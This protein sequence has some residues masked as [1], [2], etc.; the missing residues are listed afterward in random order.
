MENATLPTLYEYYTS[1]G[2]QSGLN[3]DQNYFTLNERNITLYSGAMHYFRTPKQL[4]RDRLRKMRAA[5]LN[6]VETYVA[7][8]LHE[9]TPGNFDFGE[10]GTDM[11]D[12]LD[13]E[14]FLKTAQEEDLL[15]IVRPGPYIC[16]EW[17]FGGFPSWLLRTE[18]IKFRTS[19]AIYMAA[20]KRFF[21]ALLPILA[22]LQFANGG[23]IISVQVE[24]EYGSTSSSTFTPEKQYLKEL[25]QIYLDN[26]ITALLTTADGVA[27][28]GD[29]GTDPQLFL[30]TANFGGDPTTSFDILEQ[31]QPG[32]PK[33]AMEYYPGWFDHWGDGHSTGSA[34]NLLENLVKIIA[35]PGSFN[36][37]MFH[38][39]T[40]FGFLNGANVDNDLPNN[41][42]FLPGKFQLLL[43]SGIS[44][45][46]I[47]DTTS[48]DYDAPLTEAGDYTLKY[49][50][51]KV[52]LRTVA[53]PK[54]KLPDPPALI[55]RVAYSD[56]PI[57]QFMP[58]KTLIDSQNIKPNHPHPIAMELV[59]INNGSGQSYGYLTYRKENLNLPAGA[60]L[61]LTSY[62]Y[63]SVLVLVNGRQIAPPLKTAAD[64]NSFGFYRL[65]DSEITLTDSD[66][67]NATIDL[68]VENWGRVNYGK[69]SQYYQFKGLWQGDILI[70]G[71]LVL[72]W[73]HIP[74][75]F[76]R[77]WTQNLAGW[78]D[79]DISSSGLYRGYLELEAAPEDTYIDMRAWTKGIVMVNGFV[80]GRY[81]RIGP[82]QCLY[83]PAPFLQQG[84]NEIVIFEHYE[85]ADSVRFSTDQI[86]ENYDYFKSHKRFHLKI[87]QNHQGDLHIAKQLI[88]VAKE[89][90]AD[91]AKFQKTCPKEKF[92]SSALNRPY[93]G[94]NSWGR[95]YGEHKEF[96][97]FSEKEFEELQAYAGSI[98]ILFTASAM[99]EES[100]RFLQSIQVPFIKIGSG[101]S[102]NPFLIEKA[103]Q[104]GIP[105][106]ISTG[107]IDLKTVQKI[108]GLVSKHHKNFALLQ[109]VSSYP[110]PCE[111]INLQVISLLQKSFP[112]TLIG[113]SGHELGIH[114]SVAAVALGA[115][116]IERH[117]TLDKT[118]KGSDHKCSLEPLE[119]KAMIEQMRTLQLALGK[120]I[121]K[122]EPSEEP[123]FEKLGK[124]LVYARKLSCGHPVSLEDLQIKV[125]SP[126][127]LDGW[128]YLDVLERRLNCDVDEEDPVLWRHFLPNL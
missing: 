33:M 96:L 109:C 15:A 18:D 128:K 82:Q 24:N 25:R 66:L 78:Q 9:P 58:L 27:S 48:Y 98:G 57:E 49:Q 50:L 72:N 7:W 6:T 14:T 46:L 126:K 85:A 22:A 87:G 20:V 45:R 37:Y 34:V 62:V 60:I 54:T 110:T 8:N 38:G 75:E 64:L 79:E 111:D 86:W 127:G 113:Y 51:V 21:N 83:L 42:G 89:C 11:E 88:K 74:L 10:G 99:D 63:D 118:L 93:P 70:N 81:A 32:R 107:M 80:L 124:S 17:E 30:V 97:E 125:S 68:V 104:T 120:P 26:H 91:C 112:D 12:F 28:F 4:W 123:C 39:G 2:I 65:E 55:P 23:P 1:G 122:M 5:G 67:T 106:I 95:T 36:M 84:R 92:T 90:G 35:Y 105:L 41:S 61:T 101:D 69:L 40:S 117:I 102:N 47:P 108:H 56:V 114:L 44:W 43:R 115:K 116:I 16:A 94:A 52:L 103:A 31:M 13:L 76:K 53:T 119:L 71:E 77:S 73:Q 3:A 29:A 100:L 59:D 121:K 19:D